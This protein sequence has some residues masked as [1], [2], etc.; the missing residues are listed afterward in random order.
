MV[1][2]RPIVCSRIGFVSSFC[3]NNEVLFYTP[4]SETELADA[5]LRLWRNGEE[6]AAY[7]ERAA[8]LYARYRWPE[9]R[10]RYVAVYD[11]LPRTAA[12]PAEAKE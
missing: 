1:S 5:V 8:Q 3:T 6:R 12:T 4:G 2:K 9:M 7:P 10:K 11:D